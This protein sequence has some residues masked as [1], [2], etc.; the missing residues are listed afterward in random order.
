MWI[1][2]D[3]KEFTSQYEYVKKFNSVFGGGVNKETNIFW[4][5]TVTMLE[6]SYNTT[7]SNPNPWSGNLLQFTDE[8]TEAQGYKIRK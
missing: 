3:N 2:D 7:S 4:G 6:T 1:V 8:E 5:T